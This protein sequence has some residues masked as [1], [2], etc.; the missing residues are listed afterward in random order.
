MMSC[1]NAEGKTP[2][3]KY[4]GQYVEGKKSGIGKLLLPNGE[5]YHGMWAN[6]KFHGEGT[7]YYS[8]GDI[9]SGNWNRGVKH[10]QGVFIST[11]DDSQLVGQWEKGAF[12][13]G[14][15]IWKDGTSWHGPFKDGKPL[16]KGVFYFP[17][18][19][20]QEG[21]YIQEGDAEDP[22]AELKY[23]WKGES[24]RA[25]GVDARELLR[26]PVVA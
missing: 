24:L 22:D 20:S 4:E 10:G 12:V 19:M 25:S 3:V 17:N 26:A 9:Y 5:K 18:G 16:G 6:D 23:S 21:E 15:W 13:A 2:T 14:T 8:S 7:Y 1:A 11:K